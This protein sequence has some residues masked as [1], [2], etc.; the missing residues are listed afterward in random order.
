MNNSLVQRAYPL[1]LLGSKNVTTGSGEPGGLCGDERPV[2]SDDSKR[3]AQE[4]LSEYAQATKDSPL[5][6]SPDGCPS[7]A[8]PTPTMSTVTGLPLA[9]G[10]PFQ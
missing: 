3:P 10:L 7:A 2:P 6:P 9:I 4:Q 1:G 8:G 5:D